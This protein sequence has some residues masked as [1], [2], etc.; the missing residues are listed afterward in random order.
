MI[1]KCTKCGHQ[2]VVDKP[3]YDSP[4]V[5]C[6][7]C[8]EYFYEKKIIEAALFP[9]HNINKEK[10]G[11]FTYTGALI[12]AFMFIFG[13]VEKSIENDASYLVLSI[14]GLVFLVSYVYIIWKA[15]H[16]F[17]KRKE[18]YNKFLIESKS[19]LKNKEYQDLLLRSSN[20]D[21]HILKLLKEYNST[22]NLVFSNTDNK[23]TKPKT[24]HVSAETNKIVAKENT[25]Y[26]HIVDNTSGLIC[27]NCGTTLIDDSKFC[28][29]C[30]TTI[31][32]LTIRFCRKCGRE[33]PTNSIFCNNCGTKIN[34]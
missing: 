33:L 20:H 1:A 24:T 25:A 8:G 30:G 9:P 28:H 12:G 32:T 6:S 34:V 18:K 22:N 31:N 2:S 16:T 15:S 26:E 19:R 23:T 3:L 7:A 4:V 11:F 27:Q 17:A 21:E 5:K 14:L 13:F 29:K 10:V